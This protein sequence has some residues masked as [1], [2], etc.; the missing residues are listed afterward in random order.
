MTAKRIPKPVGPKRAAAKNTLP[1]QSPKPQ[2][3]ERL[4]DAILS[5][6]I[7]PGTQLVE[8]ALAKWFDVSRTP[9]RE[10]LTRLEQ[11]AL[12]SRDRGRLVVRERS[13]DEIL[14]IYET[15]GL[16][17][18]AVARF[19][20]ERRTS[21]DVRLLQRLVE[22][23]E[24]VNQKDPAEMLAANREF[25]MTVW[26]ACHNESLIDLVRR[27][28]LHVSRFPV[29]TLSAPG[30]WDQAGKEHGAL[31]HAIELRDA[32]SAAEIAREHF[33]HARD[34]RLRLWDSNA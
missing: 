30:R 16:L 20:S 9:I 29:T 34:I 7:R 19:A 24:S 25:H 21:H 23:W 33:Q 15:R 22:R 12:L 28:E 11:D 18:A 26:R 1:T 2:P 5:N 27:I 8:S 6:E 13:P 32:N 31:V 14:D 3:Y 4:R 17:E 10:A